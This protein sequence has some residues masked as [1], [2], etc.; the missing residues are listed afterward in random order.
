MLSLGDMKWKH[1]NLVILSALLITGILS[2][3]GKHLKEK[4]D[5]S[6]TA[7]KYKKAPHVEYGINC[8]SMQICTEYVQRD[9]NLSEI[10]TDYNVPYPSIHEAAVKSRAV[11][12][13]RKIKSGNPYCIICNNTSPGKAKYFIYEKNPVE[14]VV[15]EF[16]DSVAVYSGK[17]DVEVKIRE[18]SGIIESS[19][20][21]T[22]TDQGLDYELAIKLSQLYAWSVDFYHLQ[23]G[24]AFK[25]IY[26]EKFVE[27]NPVGM[28]R[29]QSAIF[30]HRDRDFYAFFYNPNDSIIGYY[31]DEGNSIRKAFLKAPLEYSRI[32]SRYTK[33]RFHPVL[34]RYKAHLGTDYAAPTGTPIMTVGDGVIVEAGRKKYNGNY[35]KVKHNGV[36]TTQYLHM[37]RIA[38]GIR[39]GATVMQGQV[40][41]YVGMTGLATGPHLCY[42]FWKNGQQVDPFL[43]ELPPAEPIDSTLIDDFLQKIAPQKQQLDQMNKPEQAETPLASI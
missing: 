26:E 20:W 40:I 39:P 3:C 7:T 1:L 36:Y 42:R 12:D 6:A 41:G 43:E 31:D 11:F 13:V 5:E 22:L 34:K 32:S 28:G 18:A 9:Q 19:L 38:K 15:M 24:D 23:K 27:E 16:G 8:D 25:V 17:K 2:S 33:R 4:V 10:L 30:K 37:S 35:V 14:Y 29:I 21:N